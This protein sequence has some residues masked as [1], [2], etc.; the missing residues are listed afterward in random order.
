VVLKGGYPD[1]EGRQLARGDH[2]DVAEGKVTSAIAHNAVERLD[3][4][5]E[6]AN[7]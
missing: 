3:L 4:G 5:S 1:A 6:E 2:V 7:P